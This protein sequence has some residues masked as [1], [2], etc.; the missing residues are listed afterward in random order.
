MSR[1]ALI[2]LLSGQTC[3]WAAFAARRLG[4][5]NPSPTALVTIGGIALAGYVALIVAAV[6]HSRR[7]P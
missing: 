7:H 4:W 1:D 3:F 2:R 5:I 6:I